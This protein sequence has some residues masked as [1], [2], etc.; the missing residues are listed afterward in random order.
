MDQ[1]LE[2]LGALNIFAFCVSRFRGQY[3]DRLS[4]GPHTRSVFVQL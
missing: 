1:K 2:F 4:K 3:E